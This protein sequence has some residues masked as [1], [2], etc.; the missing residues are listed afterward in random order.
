MVLRN[1]PAQGGMVLRSSAPKG[2]LLLR[3]NNT[4]PPPPQKTPDQQ[5]REL[6][7]AIAEVRRELQAELDELC[8]HRECLRSLRATAPADAARDAEVQLN[9]AERE[10]DALFARI[11]RTGV[12]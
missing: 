12:S 1:W 2:G 11:E 8:S 7:G 6:L 4:P 3:T 9:S 10:L 5:L